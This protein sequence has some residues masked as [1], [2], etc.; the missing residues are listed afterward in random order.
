MLRL[1]LMKRQRSLPMNERA[2]AIK[3]ACDQ[4]VRDAALDAGQSFIVRAPAGSGKTRLLIQRYLV[5]LGQVNEPEEIIAI[6]FTR[7]AAAEM[8]ERV[9]TAFASARDPLMAMDQTTRNLAK[10]ALARDREREWQL[11]SNASRLR[12]QTIDSLNASITRQMPLAARFGAQPESMDDASA[13]YLQAAR[14]LLAEVNS[15]GALADDVATLLA[16]LDNNLWVAENLLAEMLRSR[17]HWLRNL[18]AMHEREVL[19]AA[20]VRVRVR[21]AAALCQLFPAGEINETLAL[22][23]FSG[24]KWPE[25]R[26]N[27]GVLLLAN[28]SQWPDHDENSIAVWQALADLLL[29]QAG[30]WRKRKGLNKNIGFPVGSSKDEKAVFEDAKSRMGA[31]LER[32]DSGPQAVRLALDAIRVLPPATYSDQQWQVLGAIVRLLP[33]A[34]GRLWT[35]FGA[36][37]KCDFTEIAQSASRALGTDDAPSDLALAL[38]YRIRHLLV[39][40]FQDT[41]FAQFE[42]LE[43]LTRGWMPDDGRSLLVVG[44]PMQSIYRFREAEVGLFLRAIE[45]GIGDVTLQSM[46]LSVNFRSVPG[47]VDWVNDTFKR[48]MSDGVDTSGGQVPY[49]ASVAHLDAIGDGLAVTWHPHFIRGTDDEDEDE[50]QSAGE[51]EAQKIVEIIGATRQQDPTGEIAL[52]VRNRTHLA[53]I[54][55]ALKVAGIAFRA[56]D[57]DPLKERPVVQ[58]LMALVRA[59]LHPADRIAW[60][61]LL[62]APWCGM[63]L[64][65]L[66]RLTGGAMAQAGELAIDPRTLWQLMHDEARCATLSA[67]GLRRLADLRETMAPAVKSRRLQPLRDHVENTWL[68][69]RGPACLPDEGALDDAMRLLD[70]LEAEA[71]EQSGGSDMID[72]ALFEKKVERLYSGD[73]ADVEQVPPPVQ[74]MTMH[75]AKGLEFDCVIAPA[76]HRTPRQDQRKLLAWSEQVAPETGE[77]ELLLA[78]IRETGANG[79]DETEAIYRFVRQ[80]DQEKQL[81]EDVRLLYV[82]ATRAKRHLHLLGSTTVNDGA[83]G[84]SIVAPRSTSLLASLWPVA[85]AVFVAA[86]A[87]TNEAASGGRAVEVERRSRES[88]ETL[89]PMRLHSSY[90]LPSI[91]PALPTL[92]DATGSTQSSRIDFD[93]AGESARH[94]GTVVHLFLQQIA[95]QGVPD[96]NANRVAASANSF[97]RELARLGVADSERPEAVRRVVDALTRSLADERGRWVLGVHGQAR[98]EWRLT[99]LIDGALSNIA[100]DRSFVDEDGVR[101]IIDYKTGGHEGGSTDAFLDNEQLRYRAQLETYARLLNAMKVSGGVERMRLGLYFPILG[102]WRE[103]SWSPLSG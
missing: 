40:E 68:A 87:E 49:S 54:V 4:D 95:E 19:E 92:T 20:L 1:R 96:W 86:L 27:A 13:L 74:I 64:D 7:K 93:W 2:D 83:D 32:L 5:L 56:V 84:I 65:D 21:A 39:D 28:I 72:L 67:D 43:K 101:W 9:L 55:P 53:D 85:E 33:Q 42:L 26:A 10:A 58:D 89:R 17:D 44:D 75:K 25:D 35:V 22:A 34:T 97:D 29:T 73:L 61:A 103:W 63:T 78:P 15:G 71:N 23:R 76:L 37:G 12:I 59:L 14:L 79:D 82:A 16:Y 66:A 31:L 60:L 69:L 94:V 100:I 3:P 102:G 98:S 51:E 24:Q 41:S 88:G 80:R 30:S 6:T 47:V 52:L 36:N 57:I 50:P 90:Q 11:E 8:R 48:L 38:D 62:R 46:K 45:R 91:P 99:G 81:Q 77:R 18:P 70:L